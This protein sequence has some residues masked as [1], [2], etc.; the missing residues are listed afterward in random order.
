[1]DPRDL[2]MTAL[3]EAMHL[4]DLETGAWFRLTIAG[5]ERRAISFAA[6]HF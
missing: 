4:H 2:R 1:M 3:H 6:E 5:R